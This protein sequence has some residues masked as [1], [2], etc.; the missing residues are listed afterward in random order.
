[1]RTLAPVFFLTALGLAAQEHQHAAP[2]APVP[3]QPMALQAR[4]LAEAL[5]YLG[6]PLTAAEHKRLNEAIGM[7]DEAAA[8]DA[9]Q[10]VF[11]SHVLVNVD[12]NAESRVKVEQGAAQPD[13]DRRWREAVPGEGREPGPRD[14]GAERGQPQQR[15]CVLEVE[16]PAR[17]RDY[18]HAPGIE[19]PLGRYL[20]VPAAAHAQAALRSRHRVPDP[21]NLQPRRR[22][23]LGENFFQR[24][25]GKPGHRIP[26]RRRDHC[27]TP[28]R[29]DKSRFA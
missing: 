24:R 22:P 10:K 2:P 28:R 13:L 6:Q 3:L 4:Q 8:V 1:M 14:R 23:A 27:S 5:N 9:I 26:Q 21:A 18:A 7:A 16:R 15:Q 12:I 29:P 17:S 19:G 11:D 25:A 20:A